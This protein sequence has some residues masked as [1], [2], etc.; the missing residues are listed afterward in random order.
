V[1]GTYDLLVAYGRFEREQFKNIQ[2][3]QSSSGPESLTPPCYVRDLAALETQEAN[4]WLISAM[5]KVGHS[6][7]EPA[8]Q[9]EFV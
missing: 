9:R 3:P 1:Y 7:G 5:L 8:L 4:K 6:F 2:S